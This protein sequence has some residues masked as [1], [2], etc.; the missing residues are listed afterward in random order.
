[1]TTNRRQWTAGV[2]GA[3]VM[4]TGCGA[5]SSSAATTSSTVA[6]AT[7]NPVLDAY[8]KTVAAKTAGVSLNETVT[9]TS[10]GP[11]TVSGTGQVDFASGAAQFS[12]SVP[13]AGTFAIRLVKPVLYLQFPSALKS[14]LPAGKSWVSINLDTAGKSALG[15]SFSQLSDSAGL[16]TDALSY[17]GGV[18]ATGVTTVGPA[19]VDGVQTTEYSAT[20]DLAKAA[21]QKDPQVRAALQRLEGQL[22]LSSVPVEV[23]ID[24]QGQV[25]QIAIQESVTTAGTTA[26]VQVTIGFFDFGAPVDVVP[27]PAD[28]TVDSSTLS[29]ALAG[30]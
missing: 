28:Q 6:T 1:M 9:G 14:V 24:A 5:A 10:A 27:P 4:L 19:T 21:A 20:I 8:Q 18:S 26:N 30:A 15:A 11:V 7:A 17:L 2:L 25:R 3:A 12:L 13:S 29:G 23:W 22:H 16:G